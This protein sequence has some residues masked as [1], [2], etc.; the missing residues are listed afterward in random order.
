MG[1]SIEEFLVP[2]VP[3]KIEEAFDLKLKA[4]HGKPLSETFPP[5]WD[6]LT[7]N[8]DYISFFGAI[9]DNVGERVSA[10]C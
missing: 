1:V 5:F 9:L 4:F 7:Q 3:Q 2:G 10:L 8:T 6:S